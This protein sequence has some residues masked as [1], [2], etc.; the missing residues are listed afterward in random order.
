MMW[1]AEEES[2]D[3]DVQRLAEQLIVGNTAGYTGLA[4]GSQESR[5]ADAQYSTPVSDDGGIVAPFS[6]IDVRSNCT[7]DITGSRDTRKRARKAQPKK[8]AKHAPKSSEQF[9]GEVP[10][11]GKEVQMQ[12]NQCRCSEYDS[13][14]QK[15]ELLMKKYLILETQHAQICAHAAELQTYR[16]L[17]NIVDNLTEFKDSMVAALAGVQVGAAIKPTIGIK[18]TEKMENGRGGLVE[19]GNAPAHGFCNDTGPPNETVDIG[20]GV[21]VERQVLQLIT[22]SST[23]PT[24]MVRKLFSTLFKSEEVIGKSM[25]GRKSNAHLEREVKEQ[26]DPQ[27]VSAILDFTLNQYP[28]ASRSFLRQSLACKV[29]QMNSK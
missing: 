3:H 14:V 25:S 11:H 26:L 18:P 7:S 4:C 6:Q 5:R 28:F 9:V 15:Y 19:N 12:I 13:L 2:W 10:V 1:E 23:G 21:L 27:R 24:K 22:Q 29:Q 8:K 17:S 16:E 20:H